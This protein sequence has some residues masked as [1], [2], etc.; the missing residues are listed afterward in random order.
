MRRCI[1][2]CVIGLTVAV[3]GL[4]QPKQPFIKIGNSE[5]TLGMP[6]DKILALLRQDFTVICYHEDAPVQEWLVSAGKNTLPFGTVYVKANK[7][8]GVDHLLLGREVVSSEDIFDALFAASLKLSNEG[9]NTCVVTTWTGYL[10]DPRLSKASILL[11]CGVYRISLL[12]NE[13]KGSD[14]KDLT[15]Y[16]A[17][18]ELGTTD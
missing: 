2:L 1:L 3:P 4:G 8:F 14:G 13:F 12:R 11:N 9:Q 15:G 16:L 6:A 18:E 7:V 17:R 5:I 10:P